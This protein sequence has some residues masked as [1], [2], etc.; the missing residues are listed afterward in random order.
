MNY[1]KLTQIAVI[2]VAAVWI[3]SMSLAI[4]LVR[5]RKENAE[6]TTLPVLTTMAPTFLPATQT[7]ESTVQQTEFQTQ[8]P[9]SID[10]NYQGTTVPTVGDPD[11]LIAEKESIKASEEA[12]KKAEA[13][14]NV[15][16]EKAD[17]ITA[18]VNAV[19]ELK[20]T[21]NFTLVKT[22]N[23]NMTIDELTG[24][25]T[26]KGIADELVK[27]NSPNGTKTYTFKDGMAQETAEEQAGKS[28]NQVIAPMG[29]D[30]AISEDFVRSASAKADGKGGYTLKLTFGS[31][32]QTL[33]EEAAGY[34]SCMEVISLEALGLPSSAKLDEVSIEYNN[35]YIEAAINKDGKLTSMKHY[36]QVPSASGSGKYKVV[37][38]IPVEMKAHGDFTSEYKIS[39]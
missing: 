38:S 32:T 3:F 23:L 17:I 19:N 16:K 12:S 14:K 15:P 24:G 31:Q 1:K 9:V 25:D 26:I 8:P 37:V 39:Y 13:E 5:I 33:T 4:G 2:V 30:T 36:M 27:K 6:T 7:S 29:K 34:A 35:S 11:W 21:K 20:K 28:P 18:Y 22:N 10:G